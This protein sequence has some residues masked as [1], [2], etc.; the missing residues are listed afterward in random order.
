MS[1]E[2]NSSGQIEAGAVLWLAVGAVVT[3][4]VTNHVEEV[5][6]NNKAYSREEKY[7]T[8][9]EKNLEWQNRF[10]G[11]VNAGGNDF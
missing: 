4:D 3:N 6:G 2:E 11:M 8:D 7:K 1:T 10:E 9:I 5:T